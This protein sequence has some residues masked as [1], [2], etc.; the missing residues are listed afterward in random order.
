MNFLE[1][2][3]GIIFQPVETI[4]EIVRKKPIWQAI[5]VVIITGLLTVTSNYRFTIASTNFFTYTPDMPDFGRLRA[6]L[7]PIAVFSSIFIVPLTYFV[8]AAIYHFLAEIFEGKMYAEAE[9][10]ASFAQIKE[11]NTENE[12]KDNEEKEAVLIGTA[13]G[14]YSAMGFAKLPMIFMVVVNLIVRLLNL[15]VGL[16]VTYLFLAILTI[17][18]IVLDIIAIRENYKMST[19][20][21][22]LVYFLPY[23]VLVIL[24]IIM[25]IVAGATFISVFSEIL[26][27]VP[28]Q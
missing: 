22:V 24:F 9:D 11:D 1:R 17:W 23:I 7:V 2:L 28:M 25:M 8:Y 26:N 19:G 18:I 27:N 10:K 21:A 3:Y 6:L 4:K 13:K 15:R 16:I 20:N 5:V 14:L 12:L